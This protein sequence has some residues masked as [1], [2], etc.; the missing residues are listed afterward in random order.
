MQKPADT[1]HPIHELLARLF[2]S[3]RGAGHAAHALGCHAVGALQLQPATLEFSG[4]NEGHPK[5][6]ARM[7]ACLEEPNQ[8]WAKDAPMLMIAVAQN[9]TRTM[10][11]TAMPG[12]T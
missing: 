5:E 6:F 11:P 9:W 10:T 2:R 12:T 7:L 8:A 1:A 3:T 4:R